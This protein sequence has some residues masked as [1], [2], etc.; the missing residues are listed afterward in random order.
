MERSRTRARHASAA[1]AIDG[2]RQD[3]VPD[4]N[5]DRKRSNVF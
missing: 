1:T 2:L 5:R 3:E 4:A